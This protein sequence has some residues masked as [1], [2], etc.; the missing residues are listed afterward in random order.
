MTMVS[1]LMS[2]MR[3]IFIQDY[4]CLSFADKNSHSSVLQSSQKD[5]NKELFQSS[6]GIAC[7]EMLSE[8]KARSQDKQKD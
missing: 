3:K 2:T 6:S 1:G 8:P 7:S 4:L 5:C